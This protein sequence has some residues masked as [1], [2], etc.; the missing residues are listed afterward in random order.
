MII[1]DDSGDKNYFTII[2]NYIANHSTAN[3]QALYLQM[4]KF[5]GEKGECFASERT[6]RK[7]LGIGV[8]ALKKS[9]KYLMEHGWIKEK[10]LRK[11]I[12]KGGEQLVKVYSIVNIWKLNTDFYKGVLQTAPL[13]DKGVP[14][15]AQGCSPNE[16]KGV[17]Q[18]APNKNHREEELCNKILATQSVAGKEINELIELFK[19]INPSYEKFFS[20]TTQRKA[21]ERLSKKIGFEKMAAAI[22]FLE[23]SNSNQYAPTITTPL[24]LEDKL[25][26]LVAFANKEKLKNKTIQIL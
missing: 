21:V 11:I 18:T 3:D 23:K 15:T 25:A 13:N 12:T 1:E 2:P 5:A 24:Q 22:K 8:N 16:I 10:G 26:S 14:E 19:P 20:N 9:I 7:K 6:L 17:L 4:K